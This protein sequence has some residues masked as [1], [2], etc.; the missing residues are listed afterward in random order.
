MTYEKYQ[1]KMK[2]LVL[3]KMLIEEKM[4]ELDI[5]RTEEVQAGN[6]NGPATILYFN[7]F[8]MKY[9]ICKKI[10]KIESSMRNDGFDMAKYCELHNRF[11]DRFR[12]AGGNA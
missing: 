2:E 12:A 4:A 9:D 6:Y 7:Y 11:V 1:E 5:K 3:T 10:G 8:E